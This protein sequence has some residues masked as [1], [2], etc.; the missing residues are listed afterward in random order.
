MFNAFNEK[1]MRKTAIRNLLKSGVLG[2]KRYFK[3]G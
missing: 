2:I 1:L 3:K